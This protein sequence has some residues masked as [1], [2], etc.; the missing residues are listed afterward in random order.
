MDLRE[1]IACIK[2]H[3]KE[4]RL[5]NVDPTDAI[6]EELRAYFGTQNVRITVGRTASGRPNGVA[7]LSGA[8]GVLAVVDVSAL[9]ELQ[10]QRGES[11]R[12]QPWNEADN[13][14]LNRAR[15]LG[16]DIPPF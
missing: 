9:R 10:Q 4:L 7:V 6:P 5:F 15:T 16:L 1:R 14:E 3:E 12:L 2:R 8:T 13:W 11:P